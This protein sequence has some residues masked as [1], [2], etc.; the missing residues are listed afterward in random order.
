[1][2]GLNLIYCASVSYI[3]LFGT[4]AVTQS[5]EEPV[6]LYRNH[7]KRPLWHEKA[8]FVDFSAIFMALL[9]ALILVRVRQVLNESYQQAY[10]S[11]T[12]VQTYAS[13]NST[14]S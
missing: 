6:L 11:K 3:A 14:G 1:M 7:V 10:A 8:G 4:D 12:A 9:S 13:T 2:V 5:A